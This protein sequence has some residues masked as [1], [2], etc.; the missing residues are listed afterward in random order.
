M[1]PRPDFTSFLRGL[2]RLAVVALTGVTA[3]LTGLA[4]AALLHAIQH[5]E[6]AYSIDPI[7]KDERFL[8]CA[9]VMPPARRVAVLT[10][11]GAAAG[12]SW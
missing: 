4:L 3:G 12:F 10:V 2:C 5:V 6:S 9:S 1:Q 11:C 7:F 8:D